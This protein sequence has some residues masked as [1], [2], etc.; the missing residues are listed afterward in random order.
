MKCCY[1]SFSI[2]E[3]KELLDYCIKNNIN[4]II[5]HRKDIY[6]RSLSVEI[7]RNLKIYGKLDPNQN[8]SPFSINI[9]N[10]KNN[11]IN[12]NNMFQNMK[13]YLDSKK[14]NYYLMIFEEIYSNK[15]SIFDLFK[16]LNINI[17]DNEKLNYYL[18]YDYNTHQKLKLVNNLD[19]VQKINFDNMNSQ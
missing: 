2:T 19:E 18:N 3:Y 14:Y 4:I 16:Q 1:I 12:Y 5:L 7:A 17:I 10:Y 9:N 6:K 13:D 15:S 8:Y 11:I